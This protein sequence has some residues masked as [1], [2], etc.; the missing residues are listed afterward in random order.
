[1]NKQ[2]SMLYNKKYPITGDISNINNNTQVIVEK[3]H[4]YL[5]TFSL[6]EELT[7]MGINVNPEAKDIMIIQA[8]ITKDKLRFINEGY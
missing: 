1:M 4:P 5:A 8:G 2:S 6:K 3:G 7:K